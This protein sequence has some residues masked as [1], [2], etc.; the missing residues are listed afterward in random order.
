MISI[1]D[2]PKTSEKKSQLKKPNEKYY[3]IAYEK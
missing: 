3:S 1:A 2:L